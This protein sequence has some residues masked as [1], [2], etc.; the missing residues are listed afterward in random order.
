MPRQGTGQGVREGGIE[1]EGKTQGPG[2]GGVASPAGMSTE[3][4]TKDD[5][6]KKGKEGQETK[7]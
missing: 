4:L 7:R 3:L 2:K 5:S 1:R 6:S